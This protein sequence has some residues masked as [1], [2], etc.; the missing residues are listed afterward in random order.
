MG[1]K[2]VKDKDK[3]DLMPVINTSNLDSLFNDIKSLI[4]SSRTRV[5]LSVNSE[6]VILYWNVGERI[7]KDILGQERAEYGKQVIDKLS[8]KLIQEYGQGFSRT[9]LFN[10]VRFSEVFP[11]NKI[12][13]TVSGQLSWSHFCQLIY[14]NDPLSRDFYTQM[15]QIERWSVRTLNKKIQGMLYERTA[16]SRKPE[17]LIKQELT[18]L[19]ETEQMSP[20]LIFRDP[21]MLDFLRLAD[22]YSEHD[23]ESAILR[24]IGDFLM[25]LG[26][27]FAFIARQ[28]RITID[29]EDYY[30]DLLFYN[31][32]LRRLIAIDLKLGKFKAS[33]KGQMELYLRWLDKYE[34]QPYEESPLGL[35]LCAGKSVEHIEL[36]QLEQSG[37]RVAEYLTELL[38]R[39]VLQKKLY[40]VIR[41]ARE[42]LIIDKKSNGDKK[43]E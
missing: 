24:E 38:P 28:K 39:E 32:R 4:E 33:D 43:N 10:M 36:L 41:V 21:Y 11:D 29:N 3:Q 22:T 23:L 8:V 19:K 35:I 34:R 25:E 9:N 16:I 15:C 7:R 6:M 5:A 14:L 30:I 17:E 18:A 12:V 20:D 37:I 27:D 13:Q 2:R 31:R 42:R 26:K 1:K 40:E